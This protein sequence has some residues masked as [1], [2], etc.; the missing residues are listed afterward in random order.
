MARLSDIGV[1]EEGV[2]SHIEGS[3]AFRARLSEMGFVAGKSVR[4]LF[5]APTGNPIVFELMGS[6]VALRKSEAESI[7]IA[8][9]AEG[10]NAP[11]E[12]HRATADTPT[13]DAADPDRTVQAEATPDGR[14]RSDRYDRRCGSASS[15]ASPPTRWSF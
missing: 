5:T 2:I 6:Q 11:H 3:G 14:K 4:K 12:A 13:E 7:Q 10:G 1:G 8:D 9:A 15:T